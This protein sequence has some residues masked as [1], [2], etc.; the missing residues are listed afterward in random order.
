MQ[1]H[2]A[3]VRFRMADG[4]QSNCSL[5]HPSDIVLHYTGEWIDESVL[6]L[7]FSIQ[8]QLITA[9]RSIVV[10]E[11]RFIYAAY[12][13][14]IFHLMGSCQYQHNNLHWPKKKRE[15]NNRN[16]TNSVEAL[17]RPL[18]IYFLLRNKSEGSNSFRTLENARAKITIPQT[19]TGT[20]FGAW[21]YLVESVWILCSS[22]VAWWWSVH[23]KLITAIIKSQ[24]TQSV[25]ATIYFQG[26][27]EVD[28]CLSFITFSVFA[29]CH[30]FRFRE[31]IL[32]AYIFI[33]FLV[34]RMHGCQTNGQTFFERNLCKSKISK[35]L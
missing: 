30:H 26:K 3:P 16:R 29:S 31:Q 27:N 34:R 28:Y 10:A 7:T 25:V 4:I 12:S 33:V 32:F 19:K 11:N 5:F 13:F 22:T 14:I 18:L 6:L 17:V 35:R 9:Q 23:L 1:Y 8:K 21:I 20:Y 2:Q 15:E 24:I